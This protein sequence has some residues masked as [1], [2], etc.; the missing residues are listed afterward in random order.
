MSTVDAATINSAG[1]AAKMAKF[2]RFGCDDGAAWRAALALVR[3]SCRHCAENLF[4]VQAPRQT[5][6]EQRHQLPSVI[7]ACPNLAAT[8]GTLVAH[9]LM[10]QHRGVR[11][12]C[13]AARLFDPTTA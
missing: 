6:A 3:C 8:C 11:M 4:L 1:T 9:R 2:A 5:A 13:A 7:Y 12:V 10:P